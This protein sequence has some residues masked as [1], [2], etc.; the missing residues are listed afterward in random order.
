ML[1]NFDNISSFVVTTINNMAV[2][3]NVNNFHWISRLIDGTQKR[4]TPVTHV[5]LDIEG[6][7]ISEVSQHWMCMCLYRHQINMEE[8]YQ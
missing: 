7:T 1:K 8:T 6:S 2:W 4:K 3:L 5:V